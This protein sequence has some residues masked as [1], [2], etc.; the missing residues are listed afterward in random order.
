MN[1]KNVDTS[2]KN[3]I[4]LTVNVDAEEFEK[5][6]EK[7]YRKNVSKINVPGFRRGKVP[8]KI[9]ERM[10]GQSVFYEDAV[11]LAYPAAI[12]EAIKESGIEPVDQ[13]DV[14][15]TDISQEGFTFEAKLP[16]IPEV[17]LGQYKGLS[18][19]MPEASVEDSDID[20]EIERLRGRNARQE[21]VE[22]AA[23]N[24][25]IV[26]LDF[27]GFLDDIPFEGG[28]A[29]GYMLE[30]GSE[31]FIP[32]F[33]EQLAGVKAGDSVDI[34]VA[35]PEEYH[36][37]EL[38]G[39]PAVFKCLIHEVRE[40]VLPELDDEFA[41]DVSEFDT[42]EE[43]RNSIR[44]RIEHSRLHEAEHAFEDELY[45]KL[46]A[47]MEVEL[48][49]CMVDRQVDSALQ[50]F[51]F[52]LRRQGLDLENYIQMTGASIDEIRNDFR[53][54][55]ERRV[56]L[57][58]AFDKIAELEAIEATDEDINEEYARLAEQHK[59]EEEKVRE[60]IPLDSIKNDI[61]SMKAMKLV[62]DTSVKEE[63]KDE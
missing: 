45:D 55:A 54:N 17:T 53:P 31:S 57:S 5:A 25:D 28:K 19:E 50:D 1:I 7:A 12:D 49:D 33:E 39:K 48:H 44:E 60:Y 16:I 51:G 8:R 27:E 21:T 3:F 40:N 20:A 36:E 43:F 59:L 6:V 46:L 18:A 41:K 15:I 29:E 52:S 58:L 34:T 35:F 11:N 14:D 26:R 13:A 38:A 61:L 63:H 22:R 24:G 37:E 42:L 2:V 4:T 30:L 32:G 47:G 23:E 10:Y 62:K 9:A 56:K